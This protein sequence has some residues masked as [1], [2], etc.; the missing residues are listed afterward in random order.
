MVERKFFVFEFLEA[1]V[2]ADVVCILLHMVW[3]LA[4]F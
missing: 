3:G 1:V 2:G 4:G